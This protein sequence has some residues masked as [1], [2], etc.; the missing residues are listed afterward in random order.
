MDGMAFENQATIQILLSRLTNKKTEK[1]L[2]RVAILYES[3]GALVKGGLQ[4]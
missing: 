3:R 1:Y 2:M 4:N